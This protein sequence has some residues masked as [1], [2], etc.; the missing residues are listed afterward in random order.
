MKKKVTPTNKVYRLKSASAPLALMIATRSSRRQPLLWYDEEKNENRVLRYAKNQKSP[1][2]DEQDGNP[3]LEPVVF[4]DG[5][6][7]VPKSNPVLQQFLAYHPGNGSIFEEANEEKD[8]TEV[9]ER[10]NVEVDALIAARELE[11]E[12]VEAVSRVLFGSKSSM[13]TTAELKRDL[14][15]YAK[16]DPVGFLDILQDSSL[17]LRSKVQSF[18]DAGL[19]TFRKNN[20]EVWYN[21]PSNKKKMLSVPFGDEP[22]DS[23]TSYLQT[24]EGIEALKMLESKM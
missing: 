9:V 20:T 3:I 6:L 17:Q 15:I 24:D 23:V 18:F 14:L 12:Q 10:L 13:T 4:E 22:M 8:A 1:F 16:Q 21:T 5:L 19:L 2:E 11:L 7:M